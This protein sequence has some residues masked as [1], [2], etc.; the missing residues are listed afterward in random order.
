LT[1]GLLKVSKAI[2][3]RNGAAAA[4]QL[5]ARAEEAVAEVLRRAV[6]QP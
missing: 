2:P 1:R 5:L 4:C 3:H 6:H